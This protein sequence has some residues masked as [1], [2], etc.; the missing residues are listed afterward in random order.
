M[1][2]NTTIGLILIGLLLTVFTIIN[3]PT[4]EDIQQAKDAQKKSQTVTK[5]EPAAS[6]N[7]TATPSQNAEKPVN[8]KKDSV[9]ATV[10]KPEK[11]ATLE[12]KNLRITF[13]S[14][15][16]VVQSVFLKKHKS[17][18]TFKS[19][20]NDPLC[21]FD[22]G[23]ASNYV[24]LKNSK[25]FKSTQDLVFDVKEAPNSIVFTYPVTAQKS[26]VI[27]YALNEENRLTY[28]V[29]F[30]GFSPN[31]LENAALDWAMSFRKTERKM[32]EQR[33]ITTICY[34][35]KESGIDYLSETSDDDANAEEVINWVAYKQ[36]YFSSI[37][38]PKQGFTKNT[39]FDIKN[40]NEGHPRDTTHIKAMKSSLGLQFNQGKTSFTWFFGDNDY[41]TLSAYHS[42]Y[43]D[44]LNYGWG[45]F[46]WINLYAVQPIFNLLVTNGVGIGIA[47][48]LLTIILK[49][50]LM[51]IQWK[52]FVSSVKMRILKPEIEQLNEKYPNKEDALK[53]Q[54]EMMNLYKDSGA[55]PLAGCVPMLIQM[56]ILLAVFRFFPA[57]FE[58]R[59]QPFLWAE[60][61]SS[62][63]SVWDFGFHVWG[64]GDHVSLFTLLMAGTTLWYTYMNSGNMQQPKQPGMPDMRVVMYIFP[65]LMIFFFNDFSSGLSYY[66]FI[67]TLISIIIM[68]VIKRF[69]VD[70]EKL[71]VKM[72][73]RM[74]KAKVTP[75]KKSKFQER[76]EEMQ[77]KSI[78]MQKNN[79]RK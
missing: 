3:R 61:L 57:A 20:K 16:A 9:A 31:E 5:S 17:Y 49:L 60:D 55:S 19:K 70:E 79:K 58:L 37:L 66:Y 8:T 50:I 21:L 75:K 67:S 72:E 23:D 44:I 24:V 25:D 56:P 33:R 7:A 51:P 42:N 38:H 71:R 1:D 78:E 18:N 74:A 22:V 15:G 29:S 47:I 45:L 73:E 76:L 39:S 40:Y 12:N 34:D 35:Q 36:S 69:F 54:T 59:Q 2:R 63:D 28:D 27:A 13:S 48:L 65:V 32:S 11:I 52:M 62:Y 30:P 10:M 77:K 26:V 53:K 4:E 68:V 14:K 41:K 43:D 64:Y 46:R 6:T